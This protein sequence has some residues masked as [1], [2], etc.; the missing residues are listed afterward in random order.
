MNDLEITYRNTEDL[1]PY[2]AN[3][4]THS[5]EQVAQIA[6]SMGEFGWTNPIL[7]DAEGGII[8]GHGRLLAAAQVGLKRVP[9]IMLGHLTE[10]QKKALV[11]A[12]NQIA[13]NAGWDMDI[14]KTE[15]AALA[16]ADYDLSLLGFD[17]KALADLLNNPT[18]GLT[19]PDATPI[20]PDNP[21]S[22]GGDIWILGSHRIA[23]GSSTDADTVAAL[24][25]TVR[26]NLMVTDPPYGVEYNANWR[27]DIASLKSTGS[28]R[29][30][31]KVE[32]DD[33]ADWREAWA[34]F[35]GDVAY[36]WHGER[37][38]VGLATELVDC[39]FNLRNLIVWSKPKLVIGRGNY[40]SQHET[41]W[42]AVRKNGTGHWAGDR[43]QTTLWQIDAPHRNETGHSTQKPVEAMRRPI[44]NNSSPGQAVYEPFSGSG[45][46]I[47]ACEMEGRIAYAC[48]LNPA[49]VD[50][51]VQRWQAFTGQEAVL[52][53]TGTSF[54]D[55]AAERG[56]T[57]EAAT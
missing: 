41:C 18:E 9:T 38:L 34:L 10:D 16:E 21:V 49:Y 37:Q 4:R 5:P 33:K 13:L 44:L 3:A 50:V 32:N 40:H 7:I 24:L 53:S 15:L 17:H 43:K 20:V 8:A 31:G 46:T 1:A 36:V 35:P 6:A 12:D 47:I 55:T 42:Y 22:M 29:A 51:A 11:I 25:G 57:L 14:L 2:A 26:P 52:E 45:T 27:A 56:V 19:D 39:G 23:C 54:N 30:K 28:G 48:E